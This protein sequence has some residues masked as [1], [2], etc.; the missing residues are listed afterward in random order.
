MVADL[1]SVRAS[2]LIQGISV[3]N[4]PVL[5]LDLYA[6]LMLEAL[7]Q[8]SLNAD[9]VQL[10]QLTSVSMTLQQQLI[11]KV[12]GADM[13]IRHPAAENMLRGLC[14]QAAI[15][16]P[17]KTCQAAD[18]LPSYSTALASM[19]MTQP[20]APSAAVPA[21][22]TATL[23]RAFNEAQGFCLPGA[24]F[25]IAAQLQS[26]L[27]A[28]DTA[29]AFPSAAAFMST[30]STQSA[31]PPAF[32]SK[33]TSSS[34]LD[35]DVVDMSCSARAFQLIGVS[36]ITP[37]QVVTI[38]SGAS[39]HADQHVPMLYEL[40]WKAA[41][42]QIQTT[43]LMPS[44]QL[45]RTSRQTGC[46]QACA[47]LM[48]SA[49]QMLHSKE[50]QFN[51]QLSEMPASGPNDAMALAL[52]RSVAQEIATGT[53]TASLAAP[54]NT[55]P[56]GTLTAPQPGAS[57]AALVRRGRQGL[58]FEPRLACSR[59][60]E[61]STLP[62]EAAD[63]CIILGGTGSIGSL[64]ASWL[65]NAGL[66]EVIM[67]GRTGKLSPAS[68]ANFS[69]LLAKQGTDND[70]SMVTIASCDTACTESSSWLY[71]HGRG[72]RRLILHAGGMLV[73]ATLPK[74][75]LSGIRQVLSAKVEAAQRA[76]ASTTCSPLAGMVLFS[77]VAALLGSAGQANYSAANGALDGL[78]AQWG[79][80]GRSM[81]A[82]QWGP[83]AGKPPP[84]FG[85]LYPCVLSSA[86]KSEQGCDKLCLCLD[87]IFTWM[88]MDVI[89]INCVMARQALA[90]HCCFLCSSDILAGLIL[91][92]LSIY[93]RDLCSFCSRGLMTLTCLELCRRWNGGGQCKYCFTHGTHGHA[94]HHPNPRPSSPYIHT[95]AAP[96]GHLPQPASSPAPGC[97]CPAGARQP[98][99]HDSTSAC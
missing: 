34:L 56:S 61:G 67:V 93:Q 9:Q 16:Q 97:I 44:P 88:D 63:S 87:V 58:L 54:Q 90:K 50:H 10:Q 71:Q 31:D 40:E 6:E 13:S 51:L 42:P 5:P 55:C 85:M 99:C 7:Q 11:V 30:H 33:A 91:T 48:A 27:F 2:Q 76:C 68:S 95:I 60:T 35:A 20:E 53:F 86:S 62:T 37:Q 79:G 84:P 64:A 65:V 25:T 22:A 36:L 3:C 43:T 26:T 23:S 8:V 1:T 4:K 18:V 14:A 38:S 77:S 70:T 66:Q 82:M 12:T 46:V 45:R 94:P 28:R 41:Q 75:S 72:T 89:F 69:T 17:A 21:A 96:P 57:Q 81:T 59:Q 32:T 15:V 92:Y 29:T 80:E 73:D 39:Q 49:Q 74:Q 24:V 78:A 83:W 98:P 19:F 47:R 52:L